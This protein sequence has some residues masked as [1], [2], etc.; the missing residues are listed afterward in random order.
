MNIQFSQNQTSLVAQTVKRLPAMQETRVWFLGWEDPLEKEMAIHS[1]TL[2]WK[3]SWMEETDRLQSMGSQ[4]VGH[5]WATSLS[6][7]PFLYWIFLGPL[8][9]IS[10]PNMYGFTSRPLDSILL[11]YVSFFNANTILF[12]LLLLCNTVWKQDIWC[13]WLCS[14]SLQGLNEIIPY[15]EVRCTVSV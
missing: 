14:R 3:I 15:S 5:D 10:W 13:L 2:A 6:L 7:S 8:S 4:R 11:V 12:W 1:S 9:N